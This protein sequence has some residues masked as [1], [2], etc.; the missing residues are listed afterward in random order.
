MKR[1]LS[2]P[3]TRT[4][5]YERLRAKARGELDDCEDGYTNCACPG[6]FEGP[7]IGIMGATIC[8]DCKGAGCDDIPTV[9]QPETECLVVRCECGGNMAKG[10]CYCEEDE[11]V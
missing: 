4:E 6:C 9:E 11:D 8:D 2:Y 3:E 7:I 1:R 5:L 10:E